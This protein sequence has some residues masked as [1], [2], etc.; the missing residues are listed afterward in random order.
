MSLALLALAAAGIAGPHALP[1][2][3]APPVT[4]AALWGASLALRALAVVFLA[5]Y[6]I[7]GLPATGVFVALT[8]WCLH[9]V[10][11]LTP[12]HLG[13]SGHRLAD[14]AMLF[15]GA[16]ILVSL[17]SASYGL[18]RAARALRRAISAGRL[19]RGPR[20]SVVVGG[21]GVLV[22]AAGLARPVVVVSTGALTVL[23]DEELGAGLDHE[24]GHIVRCHRYVL[25]AG[26]LCLA[27]G[28]LIPGARVAFDE[29]AFHLE[30]DADR[31]ALRRSHDRLALASAICKA[32]TTRTT[33]ALIAPLGG[34]RV[35]ERL[36]QITGATE[37]LGRAPARLLNAAAALLVAATLAGALMLPVAAHAGAHQLRH[38]EQITHCPG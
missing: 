16:L 28:H 3:R 9:A 35:V 15:P 37:P 25:L 38:A 31:W 1:V 21:R 34:G 10:V 29:L 19:A 6:V 20:G 8:Q 26:R 32:S 13:L 11:P 27:T 7:L 18:F 4:A 5:T 24:R 33:S 30:R 12:E 23:D 14:T 2:R 22:A 17:S 36:D